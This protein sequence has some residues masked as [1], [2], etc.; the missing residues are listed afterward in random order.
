MPLKKQ[1]STSEIAAKATYINKTKNNKPV[2]TETKQIWITANVCE[3][4]K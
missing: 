4:V 1:V 3:P 2:K